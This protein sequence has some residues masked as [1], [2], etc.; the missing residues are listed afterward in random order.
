MAAITGSAGSVSLDEGASGEIFLHV[1][2]FSMD[3]PREMH[4]IT[5][6]DTVTGWSDM[7]PGLV[8]WTGT[9][10]GF[11]QDAAEDALVAT[12]LNTD[13]ADMVLTA[14]TGRTYTWSGVVTIR[15]V[16]FTTETGVPNRWTAAFT[17]NGSPTIA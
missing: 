2:R 17:A 16:N 5:D 15:D 10:E 4:D 1:D 12:E 9:L 8:K 13:T 11:Y 6:F 7:T 14:S 3:A